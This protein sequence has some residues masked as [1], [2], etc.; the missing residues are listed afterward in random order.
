MKLAEGAFAGSVP[1]EGIARD[2]W[3]CPSDVGAALF[4]RWSGGPCRADMSGRN[5]VWRWEPW[6]EGK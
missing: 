6:R 3:W 1:M 5:D 4:W 2:A